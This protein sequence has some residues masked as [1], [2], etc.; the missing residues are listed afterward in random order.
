[1]PVRSIALYFLVMLFPAFAPCQTVPIGQWRDHSSYHHAIGLATGQDKLWC[2]GP[3]SIFSLTTT[4]YTI[5]RF[6][7]VNGLSATG[8][9]AIASDAQSDLVVVA[10]ANSLVDILIQDDTYPIDA[11]ARSPITGNK[12][13]HHILI[14]GTVAY[15][16][17][18]I[19]IVALDLSKKEVKDTYIIGNNGEKTAV[20]AMA[21]DGNFLYAATD[22]GLKKASLTDPHLADFRN[23][24]QLSGSNGLPDGPVT[25]T[26]VFQQLLVAQK[27]DSLY[28]LSNGQWQLLYASTAG[29]KNIQPAGNKLLVCEQMTGAGRVRVLSPQ[30]ATQETIQHNSFTAAPRGAIEAAGYYWIADS[31]VGLSQYAT[32]QFTSFVPNS[33]FGPAYGTLQVNNNTLWAAA[34]T[35]TDS[36]APTLNKDGLFSLSADAW[37]NYNKNSLPA[38]DSLPDLITL[39]I[40][41][42]DETVWA[43]SYG[44]GLLHLPKDQPLQVFKQNSGLQPA[45]FAPGSYR[46]SGLAFDQ[47]Q[48]CWIS[49]YGSLQPIVVR[50][51]DGSWRSFFVPYTIPENATGPLLIDDLDQKWIIAPNGN[52]LLCFNHG[53]SIDNPG[54]DQWK[55][56]RAGKGNGNLPDNAVLSIAKDKNSFIWIG[57]RKGIG[58]VQ[59]PREVFTQQGCEA[60]L[61]VVQ[62]DNFAGYLFSDEEV[63]AI[64]VD[65]ADRKWIGTKNGVWLISADGAKTLARFT[66]ANSP[67]L[68][69]D[70]KQIGIDGKTGEVYF[71]TSQGMCSY[72]STATEGT[73][74]NSD[75]LVF[76]NPVPPGYTGTIAIRGLANNAI[77]KIA[78]TDGRLVY[79]T[80]ALGGQAVWNGKDYKGRTISTGVYLVLVSDDNKQEKTVAK[81]VYI[82]K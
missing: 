54:D 22:D 58:I 27:N 47:E 8:I 78:E 56:Y 79:Q 40:D 74:S 10:Y 65:G 3:W 80:R 28:Q 69:N 72:R 33:P 73:T 46:V 52:G 29:I 66:A 30:G 9:T 6:S 59:C 25:A 13:I 76:P 39:A 48:N 37:T 44:G 24:Q 42:A 67:L 5:E 68:S 34:G 41:P 26:T 57:T 14:R 20:H 4:D 61:P 36:W 32:G 49:N 60:I 21:T 18:G 53:Q 7:K 15:L 1:M 31:L 82:S 55:W 38:L 17:T 81:I 45:Y 75:V 43:G 35:V 16:S 70:V 62:Q 19:G 64:A 2:A 77:V 51:K 50:K 71:A 12:T 23:W 11:I 63:Q